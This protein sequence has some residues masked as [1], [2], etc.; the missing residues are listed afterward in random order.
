[1]RRD[2]LI[3]AVCGAL[4]VSASPMMA[5]RQS[6][7]GLTDADIL[8]FALVL[9]HLE[10]TF[11]SQA[12]SKFDASAFTSAGYASNIRA[13]I[14][15]IAADEAQHVQFLT[16]ALSAA[17]ATPVSACNYTFPYGDSVTGFL[18]L[19]QVLE[20][21]GVSAYLGAAQYIQNPA[22]LTAAGSILTAE[23]RHSAFIR[24]INGYSP[25]VTE[26]TPLDPTSVTSLASP[27]FASCPSGSAPP[28]KPFPAANL[29]STTTTPGSTL[30]VSFANSSSTQGPLYCLFFSGLESSS[31][32]YANGSCTV[33]TANATTGQAYG[34]ISKSA[35]FND[36]NVVAGPFVLQFDVK[37]NTASGNS[38]RA[39]TVSNAAAETK[40][41]GA[42]F[43]TQAAA[44][45]LSV[46]LAAVG[47]F[48]LF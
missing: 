39:G 6:S 33:P 19:S 2:I 46:V 28:F 15:Q 5:K 32:S 17:G 22:Y 35:T 20:G 9:E 41:T 30:Q 24:F 3:A 37:N 29:T 31:S 40:S 45:G 1:M 38:S 48:F 36:S 44:G 25:F 27:F 18:G 10:A 13:N 11:Y 8:N 4:G 42:G 34:V 12:L 43:K 26:D 16:T 21:V 47:S 14:E 23:A 7:S